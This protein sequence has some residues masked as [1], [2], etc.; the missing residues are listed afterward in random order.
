MNSDSTPGPALDLEMFRQSVLALGKA[1]TAI[2]SSMRARATFGYA[3]HELVDDA[4]ASL[5]LLPDEAVRTLREASLRLTRLADER[6]GAEPAEHFR[7]FLDENP[8]AFAELLQRESRRD[9]TWLVD[10]LQREERRAGGRVG[11]TTG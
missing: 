8:K 6:L 5:R 7:R 10:F 3:F 2:T 4:R 9:P 11:R 1:F